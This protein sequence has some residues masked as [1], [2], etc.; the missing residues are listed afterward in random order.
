MAIDLGNITIATANRISAIR[1][2]ISSWRTTS[3]PTYYDN[4][5]YDDTSYAN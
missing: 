4:S 1:T 5:T 2:R 3:I